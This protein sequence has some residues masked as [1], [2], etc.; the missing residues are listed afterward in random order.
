MGAHVDAVRQP[1]WPQAE[2][3]TFRSRWRVKRAKF[4]EGGRDGR[5]EKERDDEAESGKE[6]I[7]IHG[8]FAT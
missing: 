3:S 2:R 5:A 6:E 8:R 7:D 4:K 1:H